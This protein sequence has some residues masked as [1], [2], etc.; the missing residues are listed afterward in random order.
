MR[1]GHV[2]VALRLLAIGVGLFFLAMSLNKLAWLGNPDL[3]T[4]R[5]ERW[6]PT[7]SPYAKP[8]LESVAIPGAA[9]FARLVPI[10][11]FLTAMA[12]LSGAFTRAAAG[13][14]LVMISNFHLATSAF[15]SWAFLQDGTG[16]P[17]LAA[18]LALAIA[19][20]DLPFAVRLPRRR[21][22]ALTR[23]AHPA[24]APH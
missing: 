15:S 19:G 13:M 11:E 21:R 8:Y 6:L 7:A 23:R 24:P 22:A 16:P 18:L 2:G 4:D 5:L 20:H 1:P 10:G 14:A 9:V 12:L 3:L 17:L